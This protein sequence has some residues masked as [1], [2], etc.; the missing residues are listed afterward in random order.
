MSLTMAA[1]CKRAARCALKLYG[2]LVWWLVNKLSA[3]MNPLCFGC[4]HDA[5]YLCS[6]YYDLPHKVYTAQHLHMQMCEAVVSTIISQRQTADGI[7]AS[8][9]QYCYREA[10]IP[11]DP[12]VHL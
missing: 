4:G 3:A 8:T 10:V 5:R 11:V 7:Y 1:T 2:W 6:C 9:V 12:H